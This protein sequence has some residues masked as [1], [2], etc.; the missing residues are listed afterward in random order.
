MS[1][2]II[3]KKLIQQGIEFDNHNWNQINHWHSFTVSPKKHET[4]R[5]ITDI[6]EKKK[7]KIKKKFEKLSIKP[8][9]SL[10]PND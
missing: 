8:N 5:L 6:L 2:R 1:V 9:E 7:N 10:S 3:K 4:W